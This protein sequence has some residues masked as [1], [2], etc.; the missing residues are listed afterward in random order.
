VTGHATARSTLLQGKRRRV[1]DCARQSSIV[2]SPAAGDTSPV[3]RFRH[4]DLCQGVL[5]NNAII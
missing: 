4:S 3:R 2:T 5:Y 1:L